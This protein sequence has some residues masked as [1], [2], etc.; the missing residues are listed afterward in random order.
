MVYPPYAEEYVWTTF[1]LANDDVDDDDEVAIFL[2]E[3]NVAVVVEVGL[4]VRRY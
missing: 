4:A 1:R 3:T 2:S